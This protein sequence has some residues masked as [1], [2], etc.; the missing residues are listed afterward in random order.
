MSMPAMIFTREITLLC[1][2]FGTF[3]IWR[4]TPSM[5]MRTTSPDS[6]GSMWISLARSVIARSSME[7]TRADRRRAVRRVVRQSLL[8]TNA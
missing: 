5:R 3:M 1:T 8:V 7:L 2:S 4:I 6:R